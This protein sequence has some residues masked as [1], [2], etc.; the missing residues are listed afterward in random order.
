MVDRFAICAGP[1][2]AQA[3]HNLFKWKFIVHYHTQ[4]QAIAEHE[5]LQ[6][7]GLGQSSKPSRMNPPRQRRQGATFAD[8]FPYRRIRHERATP[9]VIKGDH[10]GRRLGACCAGCSPKHVASRQMACAETLMKQIS[11]RSLAYSRCAQENQ[12]FATSGCVQK[13]KTD[14]RARRRVHSGFG[15]SWDHRRYGVERSCRRDCRRIPNSRHRRKRFRKALLGTFGGLVTS[16]THRYE[17]VRG[18]WRRHRREGG[19]GA[20]AA[21]KRNV[22]DSKS[23][24]RSPEQPSP[25][26]CSR[27]RVLGGRKIVN[28]TDGL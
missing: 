2:S 8:P 23:Q 7:L 17:V 26:C 20:T 24:G 16:V 18:L 4:R 27:R 9:H 10:R 6:G 11:L 25:K 21:K 5:F 1:A 12:G 22:L 19:M 15:H 14:L 3:L 28:G 13:G